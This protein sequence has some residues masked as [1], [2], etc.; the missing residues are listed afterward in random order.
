VQVV[1]VSLQISIETDAPEYIN[2]TV[3]NDVFYMHLT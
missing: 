1:V 2:G 3:E